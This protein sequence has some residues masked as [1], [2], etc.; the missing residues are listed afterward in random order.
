MYCEH[1]YKHLPPE[2][3][4][5]F[6]PPSKRATPA[7]STSEP[8]ARQSPEVSSLLSRYWDAYI[9]ARFTTSIGTLIKIVAALAAG[10]VVLVTMLLISQIN[11]QGLSFVI[12]MIGGILAVFIGAV[13]FVLGVL[14]SAQ[15]QI[16]KAALDGGVNN[17]PFLTNEHRA[18]I[19]SLI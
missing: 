13:L 10:G 1:C 19:M 6:I 2:V 17:S 3:K 12:F 4:A 16:L 8:T 11:Q 9:V 5:K 18:K 15:G 7:P 14:V